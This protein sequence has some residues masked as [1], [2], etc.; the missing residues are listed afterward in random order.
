MQVLHDLRNHRVHRFRNSSLIKI[1]QEQRLLYMEKYVHLWYLVQL[2]RMG[3]ISYKSCRENQ[4]R[5][6]S[7]RAFFSKIVLFMRYCEKMWYGQTGRRW[8]YIMA[9]KRCKNTG[10]PSQ[11][12]M[13]IAFPRQRG[14]GERTLKM[15][16]TYMASLFYNINFCIYQMDYFLR[17]SRT[18]L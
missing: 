11:Y 13:F 12:L 14:F 18:I 5:I 7:S 2:L 1:W 15:C 3:N 8:Q 17:F 16:Y 4:N 6:L 9:R 10:T